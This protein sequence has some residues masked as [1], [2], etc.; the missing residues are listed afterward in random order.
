MDIIQKTRDD[1]NKIATAFS[2]TRQHAGELIQFRPFLAHGQQILD[3][4]CGNGRLLY[5]LKDYDVH[6]FGLDQSKELLKQAEKNP[7]V[8]FQDARFFCTAH[9]DKK[10]EENFFDLVFMLAS[11]HHL[12]DEKT[13]R[14]LLKK[15]YDEM[16]PGALL[17]ITV[18]NLESDWAKEK[19]KKGWKKI[20]DGDYLIPWKDKEST[21]IVERYYHHFDKEEIEGLLERAGF[22]VLRSYYSTREQ[23]A[24][25]KEGKNLVIIAKKPFKIPIVDN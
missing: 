17:I 3:W 11:F 14:K 22:E 21:V 16:R 25:K 18:W 6:Y 9:K 7:M 1:Y 2:D 4:G 12:P 10:F 5:L 20:K 15:T 13:R 8:E 19:F 24:T 23:Q